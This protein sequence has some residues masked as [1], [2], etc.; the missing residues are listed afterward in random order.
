MWLK[1]ERPKFGP[2]V[3]KIPLGKGMATQSSILDWRI[4][5]TEEPGRLQSMWLQRVADYQLQYCKWRGRGHFQWL[6]FDCF[7]LGI[8]ARE[9]FLSSRVF[10]T[11][12]RKLL[13]LRKSLSIMYVLNLYKSSNTGYARYL[14]MCKQY[15]HTDTYI[16]IYLY[17]LI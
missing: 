7:I 13:N 5:W 3:K 16:Y 4:P 6:Y 10:K 15:M 14:D 9:L 1:C 2:W 12:S 17:I 11:S 8:T